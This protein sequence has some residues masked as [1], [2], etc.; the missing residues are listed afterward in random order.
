MGP[1]S[2]RRNS[3]SRLAER[4]VKVLRPLRG[5]RGPHRRRTES[6]NGVLAPLVEGGYPMVGKPSQGAR[7][8]AL[9]VALAR[10][11]R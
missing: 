6:V 4:V 7:P 9:R 1:F 10:A 11:K 8:W 3:D 2:G 5:D